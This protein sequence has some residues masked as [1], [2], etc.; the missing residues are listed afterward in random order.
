MT[1][2]KFDVNKLRVA[3]PCPT[4]WETMRG[5]S[6]VRFCDLCSLNVYNF[7]EMTAEEI[8]NLIAKSDGRICGRMYKRADG[9]ILAQDC[10]VGIRAYYKRTA[11]FASAA[12]T[13]ILGLFSISFA[14]S[15]SKKDKQTV[16]DSKMKIVRTDSGNQQ[17]SL[18]GK[19][20]DVTGAVIPNAEITLSNK[21]QKFTSKSNDDGGYKL[22][23]LPTGKYVLEVQS[24]GFK[25]LKMIN[26]EINKKENIQL[27]ISLEV[28]AFTMGVIVSTD[29]PLIDTKS[30]GVTTK[31]TREQMDK[32]PH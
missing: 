17:S 27:D 20:L 14:Q 23:S 25:V 32:L 22:N 30:S 7:S 18:S 31:I 5:D 13:A 28:G 2:Q 12:L 19:I 4:S 16:S 26:I 11:R 29:E 8:Q 1:V 21:D 10:P 15:D 9:T 24:P 6:K 3:K